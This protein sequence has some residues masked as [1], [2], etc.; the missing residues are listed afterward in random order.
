ME[1]V[2]ELSDFIEVGQ[3]VIIDCYIN[4]CVCFFD[5]DLFKEW[6]YGI[7][8]LRIQLNKFERVTPGSVGKT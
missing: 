6:L 1:S 8:R 5:S 7:F 3:S 4:Q 2:F